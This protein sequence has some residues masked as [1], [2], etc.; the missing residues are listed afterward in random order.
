MSITEL[1]QKING[2]ISNPPAADTVDPAERLA[3]LGALDSLRGVI[4]TP[5]EATGRIIFG[6]SRSKP[7]RSSNA[8]SQT[9]MLHHLQAYEQIGLRLGIEMGIFNTMASVL[10]DGNL[11]VSEIAK[12]IEADPLLVSRVMRLLCGMGLFKEIG[13]Q[14]Y[15]N[16]PLAPAFTDQSP[17]PH[18][19]LHM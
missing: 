14:K 17:F 1:I 5:V 4:E 9:L 7:L 8:Q 10:P 3:L 6:V 12:K 15:S 11:E 2:V 19:V 16:G 13:E 18:V